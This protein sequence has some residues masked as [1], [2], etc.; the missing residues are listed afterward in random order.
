M[1]YVGRYE[2][3]GLEAI[4]TIRRTRK[5]N[6]VHLT[7]IRAYVR[8]AISKSD[9]KPLAQGWERRLHKRLKTM[10][11]E[12][13]LESNGGGIRFA[14]ADT[15]KKILDREVKQGNVVYEKAITEVMSPEQLRKRRRTSNFGS[16]A[17]DRRRSSIYTRRHTLSPDN[18]G[19]SQLFAGTKRRRPMLT[20]N[21]GAKRIRMTKAQ[22]EEAQQELRRQL[23]ERQGAEQT[24]L[25][26]LA[27]LEEDL[28]RTKIEKE[29]TSRELGEQLLEVGEKLAAAREE[30]E[31]AER[32][33]SERIERLTREITEANKMLEKAR[34]ETQTARLGKE[35]D[36]HES[37]SLA[38]LES[39][40]GGQLGE[41]QFERDGLNLDDAGWPDGETLLPVHDEPYSSP[42]PDFNNDDDDNMEEPQQQQEESPLLRSS[43]R[44][45]PLDRRVT[46][47]SNMIN[48]A[49]TPP[50]ESLLEP[51]VVPMYDYWDDLQAKTRELDALQSQLDALQLRLSQT[52][53]E[54][55]Q[56]QA[57]LGRKVAFLEGLLRSTA[58]ELGDAES[59][60]E[61][62]RSVQ[63]RNAEDEMQAR[64]VRRIGRLV[65]YRNAAE[66]R[67]RALE[68]KCRDAE[69]D[70]RDK[71][72]ILRDM[73]VRLPPAEEQDDVDATPTADLALLRSTFLSRIDDLVSSRDAARA[74]EQEL[75]GEI[76]EMCARHER[77][78]DEVARAHAGEMERMRG[79]M[80]GVIEKKDRE[81]GEIRRRCEELLAA[82]E[83]EV[84]ELRRRCEELVEVK[85][86]LAVA[87]EVL[88]MRLEQLDVEIREERGVLG[89]REEELRME[90]EEGAKERE[91]MRMEVE[92]LRGQLFA[93]REELLRVVSEREVEEREGR[94]HMERMM[95]EIGMVKEEAKT[96]KASLADTEKVRNETHGELTGEKKIQEELVEQVQKKEQSIAHMEMRVEE[97]RREAEEE[98]R[99][100][101]ELVKSA[102]EEVEALRETVERLEGEL[103]GVADRAGVAE[104]NHQRAMEEIDARLEKA[105][106]ELTEVVTVRDRVLEEL[107]GERKSRTFE[108]LRLEDMNERL[109][110]E[111]RVIEENLEVVR[112]QR[113]CHSKNIDTLKAQ[114]TNEQNRAKARQSQLTNFK[115]FMLKSFER[116]QDVDESNEETAEL[117]VRPTNKKDSGVIFVPTSP[118]ASGLVGRECEE[119]TVEAI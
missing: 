89:R 104:E 65:R 26:R 93:E 110:K 19:A 18:N 14:L 80:R 1:A 79:E 115:L 109:E 83:G 22:L 23:E 85:D 70:A 98:R 112:K 45:P 61:D 87:N 64:V 16:L 101:E 103:C 118:P 72:D 111:K 40:V 97:A 31:A 13:K 15:L 37:T 39:E 9:D 52:Q 21:E 48:S 17:F 117:A 3:L 69:T 90:V 82:K 73:F 106:I 4:D 81:I 58:D 78:R 32:E 62:E 6:F 94:E 99:A 67:A 46:V 55:S 71:V 36:C 51:P 38:Q 105:Q 68:G 88:D 35:I 47:D 108:V 53:S 7:S 28:E 91:M 57:A 2:A 41:S 66:G 29:E 49:L 44:P 5:T 86:E 95:K 25:D 116:I 102:A 63:D 92:D 10:V 54:R 43:V 42:A 107:E 33:L 8:T 113:D 75:R 27:D 74:L 24:A 11:E 77:E 60:S 50:D 34:L 56:V 76:A 96:L 114:L 12:G 59:D 20:D 30:K 119:A 100:H 84:V